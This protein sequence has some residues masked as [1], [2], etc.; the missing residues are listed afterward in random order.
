M[1]I[2][3]LDLAGEYQQ[4]R[5]EIDAAMQQVLLKGTFIDGAENAALEHEL[6]EYIG[7]AEVICVNSGTDALLLSLKA[8]GIGAG[9][10]VIVP[11]FTFFATA[12]AVSLAGARPCFADCAPGQ[13]NIDVKGVREALTPRTKAVIAVHLFGQPVDLAPLQE[14]CTSHDLW[15]IEDAA[16]A[17]G[18]RYHGR[19]VGSFGITGAFS[20]YPTKNLGA[21][22]DGGAIACSDPDLATRLRRIR[23]HGRQDRYQHSEIGFNS[24][25]DELQAAIL[26]VKLPYLDGWNTQRRQLAALY[27]QALKNTECNWSAV[28]E[29]TAPVHHQFVVTHP[30]R[31]ALQLF[32]AEH[33]ISTAVFYPIPCHLQPAFAQ[34]YSGISLPQAERLA[35]RVLAL[36]IYPTLP[37]ETVVHIGELIQDFEHGRGKSP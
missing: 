9:D 36:P 29:G 15:L 33:N 19:V 6:A 5:S 23:N 35:Q 25:L 28:L 17:I 18:A 8:L 26:R 4:L 27:Q 13:Y 30:Q 7:A 3:Q 22:G 14:F 11:A 32:L 21:Y 16:Q 24:R 34:S 37:P 2:P 12:E 20:F 1:I 31:D 10:E